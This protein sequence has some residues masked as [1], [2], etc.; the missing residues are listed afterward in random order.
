MSPSGC[1]SRS[2]RPSRTAWGWVLRSAVRSSK[3]TAGSSGGTT[4]SL[5]GYASFLI[6]NPERHMAAEPL[7]HIVDDDAEICAAL[8]LLLS[9]AGWRSHTYRSGK[10]FLDA[11]PAEPFCLLLD[12]RLPGLSGLNVL[13]E[14]R[15]RGSE[16]CTIVITGHGDVPMAVQAMRGGA[17][18]FV[19]KPFEPEL[20]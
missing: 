11:D 20:L 12:V 5:K 8:S 13:E 14:L 4:L 3:P 10:A 9:T 17:F 1:S 15:K 18:H 2:R 7:V 19:E 16:A 6:C